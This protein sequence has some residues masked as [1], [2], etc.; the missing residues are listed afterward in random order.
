MSCSLG[1]SLCVEIAVLVEQ[2]GLCHLPQQLIPPD[3][4]QVRRHLRTRPDEGL[5]GRFRLPVRPRVLSLSQD[6]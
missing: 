5:P 2:D 3:I 4:P 1:V 6:V